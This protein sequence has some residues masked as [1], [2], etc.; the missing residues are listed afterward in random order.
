MFPLIQYSKLY[1]EVFYHNTARRH[2]PEDLELKLNSS[3]NLEYCTGILYYPG[4][5]IDPSP[6]VMAVLMKNGLIWR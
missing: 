1:S 5:S 6:S 2:S 4:L 3:E